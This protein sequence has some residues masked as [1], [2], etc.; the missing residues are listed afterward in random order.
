MIVEEDGK[1]IGLFDGIV[2]KINTFDLTQQNGKY[3]FYEIYQKSAVKVY[4]TCFT[5]F[6]FYV[7]LHFVEEGD[8]LNNATKIYLPFR[9]TNYDMR[10][11]FEDNFFET[12]VYGSNTKILTISASVV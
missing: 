12:I 1:D 5:S 8:F 4:L 10:Q 9:E 3:F 11:K 7:A 6:A 2:E